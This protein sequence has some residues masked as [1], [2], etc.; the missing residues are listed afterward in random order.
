M[1]DMTRNIINHR[2]YVKTS[3]YYDMPELSPSDFFLREVYSM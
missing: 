1:I 3:N 2:F